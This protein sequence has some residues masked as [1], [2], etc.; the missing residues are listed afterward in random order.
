MKQWTRALA[1]VACV[2]AGAALVR[3]QQLVRI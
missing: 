3:G 1:V 2:G